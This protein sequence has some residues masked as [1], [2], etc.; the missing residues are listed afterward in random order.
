MKHHE[1]VSTPPNAMAVSSGLRTTDLLWPS[2]ILML[3]GCALVALTGPW[4]LNLVGIP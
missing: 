2:L 4:I 1:T 3:S